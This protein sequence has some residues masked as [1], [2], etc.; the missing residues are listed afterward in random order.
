[1]GQHTN[2]APHRTAQASSF[3]APQAARAF[4]RNEKVP[5]AI[6]IGGGPSGLISA[7]RLAAAGMRVTLLEQR[8]HLGGAVGAH[9]VGGLLLDSGA[10]SFATRSPIVSDL[11]KELGLGDQ[12]VTPNSYGS[13][14]YL[15]QGARRTPST[16]IMGIPGN[17]NDKSLI[18][19]IGKSGLRRA[20]V[21]KFLPVSAGENAKTLGELVRIRMGQK[22]LDN[23]VAPVVSG[24][25]ST[26]PDKLDVDATIP[27]LREAFRKHRSL[28]AAAAAFRS[29]APAGSQVAGIIGGMNQLSERLV[30]ELYA[31]G[32]R[33]VTG[34]DVIAVD[35]DES[36][37]QWFI[38]QRHTTDGENTPLYADYLV[39]ATDGPTV[40]RLIGPHV[41][42]ALPALEP[43][44]EVALV[45]LVVDAPDLNKHPRGTGLLVS[46]EATAVRAKA[47]TH[48]TAKWQWVADAAGPGRHVVRLSYGRGGEDARF[49][50][51]ALA[52]EQLI[53]LALR[54]ATRMMGV[55]LTR[56]NLI[57][58]DVV[59]WRGVLPASTPG[60]RKRVQDFRDRASELGTL[61]T[62]GSWAAGSGL[63]LTVKDTYEQMDQLIYHAAQNWEG[64]TSP[65]SATAK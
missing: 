45:T 21:D 8:H 2:Q 42:T 12:I 59:R 28:S 24:V 34:F 13:W 1:M 22:V 38:I 52:D 63:V 62:V 49:S 10:E 39:V 46:E 17:V 50:E 60:H 47:L 4:T 15:P 51:V 20:Q 48:A 18:P 14:L 29:A 19:V 65:K 56:R 7:R 30:E 41:S 27:G 64:V 57:D 58:A 25:Y 40:A 35:R 3:T 54:D 33:I 37:G 9:E 55:A 36:T 44:P 23:L 5:T 43:G 6:V 26:H 16:G 31:A 53:T 11:V 32:V 61:S